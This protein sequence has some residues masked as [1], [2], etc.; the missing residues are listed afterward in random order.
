MGKKKNYLGIFL[1]FCAKKKDETDET[2]DD[3]RHPD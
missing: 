3:D 1:Y 2:M